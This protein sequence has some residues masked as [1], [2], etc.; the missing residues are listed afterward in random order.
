MK[1]NYTE[2][3]ADLYRFLTPFGMINDNMRDISVFGLNSGHMFQSKL[4]GNIPSKAKSKKKSLS[5]RIIRLSKVSTIKTIRRYPSFSIFRLPFSILLFALF[6]LT[7]LVSVQANPYKK[8]L[9]C[10]RC[11]SQ[12]IVYLT[13]SVGDVYKYKMSVG[14][15]ISEELYYAS[16]HKSFYCTACHD[17]EY[18]KYPH[19]RDL[20][21]I[22]FKDCIDCHNN[23]KSFVKIDF[24]AIN[25]DFSKSVH[26]VN[27]KKF[28]CS[29]CHDPHLFKRHAATNEEVEETITYDNGVCLNCH[30][31]INLY[32]E[33]SNAPLRDLTTIH[34]WL[35]QQALHFKHVRCVECHSQQTEK[36]VVAHFI[37]SR[38]KAV[39]K[40]NECHSQTPEL[41]AKL[42]KFNS[43][44]DTLTNVFTNSNILKDAFI[45]G[46]NKSPLL[47][48][49]SIAF[50]AFAF[51]VIFVHA[52]LRV[53]TYKKH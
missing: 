11:H 38:A 22:P 45:I 7:A 5:N 4:P 35:P 25:N 42:Y 2:N 53:L 21:K 44:N 18:E 36:T 20:R 51:L 15:V 19:A 30:S 14:T 40:C 13:D 37:Q 26:N 10:F 17:K 1:N 48:K 28:T 49:I 33:Y 6:L 41:L 52:V 24:S 8:N 50:F 23:N 32:K 9:K 27:V 12:S 16:N 39:R 43:K 47:N 3:G 34:D 31:K 29:K 46:A